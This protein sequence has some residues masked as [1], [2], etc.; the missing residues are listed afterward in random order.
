MWLT[1]LAELVKQPLGSIWLFPQAVRD[2]TGQGQPRK[3]SLLEDPGE[4]PVNS[5]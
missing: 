5:H 3:W 4:P 1:T 2:A